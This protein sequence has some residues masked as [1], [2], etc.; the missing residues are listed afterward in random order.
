MYLR[1]I[2]IKNYGPIKDINYSLPF[3]NEGNPI[4]LILIGKN[5]TGKT[6]ILSNILHSLI[7][8]KR[9]FYNKLSDVSDNNYYRLATTEYIK[10]NENYSYI[11]T[12]FD[13]NVYN[14]E[15]LT[16]NYEEFLKNYDPSIIADV[17]IDD[18]KFK[19]EGF[20]NNLIK[21][22]NNV[23][24]N[25]IYLYFPVDRFYIPTWE[26]TNNEK[27]S[28]VVDK[29]NLIGTDKFGIVQYNLL[30]NLEEWILD[31]IIDKMLYEDRSFVINNDGKF[32]IQR[33]FIG[34][35]QDI[36]NCINSILTK[37]FASDKYKSIR[38]GIPQ[39]EY[40]KI[41]IIGTKFDGTEEDII[42][43]FSNLSSGE[44]MILGIFSSIIKAYD[45]IT[46]TG[47]NINEISGIVMVDEIDI[48]LHSDLLKDVLPE[49]IKMFPKI[50]FIIT[51]HSPFFLLGMKEKCENNCEFLAL[52][53]GV[54]LD[55][56]EEFEEIKKCYSIVD[57][58]YD[59]MLRTL[60]NYEKQIKDLSKPLII[61]EGKTDWKHLKHAL[62]IMKNSGQ[63][64]NLDINFLEYEFEFSDSKLETLL[65]NLSKVPN[66]NKIIGIFDSDSNIGSKYENIKDFGN[67]VYGY[68]IKDTQ[69]Y[70]CGISIELLYK[71]DDLTISDKEGRRIYL[72]DEFKELSHQLKTN[73]NIVCNNKTLVDAVKRN[74]IK[75]ID[76]DVFDD[77]EH[78]LALS[79]NQFAEYIYNNEDNFSKVSIDGFKDIFSIIEQIIND[80]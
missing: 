50:Q 74:I 21:P 18:E 76:S 52:P 80:N 69:G 12:E 37:L 59:D 22:N 78:S 5:G 14:L 11:K 42:P 28:F 51:S 72:T 26:N 67:N 24:K 31:V 63:Y 33:V 48:H 10:L 35:N 45:K 8:I 6:L 3:N 57:K 34:K 9:K 62:S 68:C 79:K 73:S 13:N 27:I 75:I 53:N 15:L 58:N 47:F 2:K 66:Q 41:I 44:M 30:E 49:I 54:I 1:N 71:R 16:N 60:D 19:T 23:F 43:R 61:T 65:I 36:Q 46:S 40:R 64:T 25:N 56:I 55:N 7:E 77:E 29:D 17:N 4:P 38:I 32:N 70:N 39:K 20:F